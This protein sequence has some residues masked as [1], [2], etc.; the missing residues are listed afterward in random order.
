ML[1]VSAREGGESHR[2]TGF[3]QRLLVFTRTVSEDGGNLL[4]VLPRLAN[5]RQFLSDEYAALPRNSGQITF[6]MI[7]SAP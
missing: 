6:P 4:F 3:L 2:L 1:Y 5:P 7:T